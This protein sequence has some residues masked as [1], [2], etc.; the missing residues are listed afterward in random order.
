MHIFLAD[1]LRGEI[2]LDDNSTLPK[3]F[4]L[5][6]ERILPLK[7]DMPFWLTKP[8]MMVEMRGKLSLCL[9]CKAIW[10]HLLKYLIQIDFLFIKI[11]PALLQLLLPKIWSRAHLTFVLVLACHKKIFPNLL[12]RIPFRPFFSI[13]GPIWG[14]MSYRLFKNWVSI[15]VYRIFVLLISLNLLN[16]LLMCWSNFVE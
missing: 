11:G 9:D 15:G 13:D 4:G 16:N 8:F 7:C 1:Y 3:Y 2:D 10:L 14:M 5:R 6:L 12:S